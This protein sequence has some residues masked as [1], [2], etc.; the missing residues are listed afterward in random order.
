MRGADGGGG[1]RGELKVGGVVE[2]VEPGAS[3]Q[4]DKDST[5]RFH[6][7]AV[8]HFVSQVS[9]TGDGGND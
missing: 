9:P 6:Q 7:F 3:K 1:M 4:Q 5:S 8:Q 2:G